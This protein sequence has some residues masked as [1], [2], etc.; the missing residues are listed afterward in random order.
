MPVFDNDMVCA[1]LAV[2]G[3]EEPDECVLPHCSVH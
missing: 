3:E 2:L 1:S